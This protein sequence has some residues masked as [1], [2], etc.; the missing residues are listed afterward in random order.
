MS[1]D[2]KNN[3]VLA[4]TIPTVLIILTAFATLLTSSLLAYSDACSDIRANT[5]N[6][7]SVKESMNAQLT[8]IEKKIDMIR[9]D[10]KALDTK[11]DR[12]IWPWGTKKND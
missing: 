1:N 4:L 9:S 6:L 12:T 10:V 5:E 7:K 2:V 11:I 3:K 8:S